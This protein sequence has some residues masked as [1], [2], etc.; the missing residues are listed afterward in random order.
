M[1]YNSTNQKNLLKKLPVV[2]KRSKLWNKQKNGNVLECYK[3]N[4]KKKT[5]VLLPNSNTHGSL[6]VI[7]RGKLVLL[8]ANY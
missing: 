3:Q 4:K 6:V 7:P 8:L 2:D 1:I 5:V